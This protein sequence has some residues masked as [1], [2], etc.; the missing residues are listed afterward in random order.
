MPENTV[1]IGNVTI[2]AVKD[3]PAMRGDPGYMYRDLPSSAWDAHKRWLNE[4][5]HLD[6]TIGSF[7]VRSSGRSILVDTGIGK[8]ERPVFRT[9]RA[10]LLGNLAALGVRPEDVDLVVNTHL[11]VDHVGWNTVAQGDGWAPAFPRARYLIQ[12]KEWE[13]FTAPER[14][15]QVAYV[16]DCLEPV[17]QAGLLDLVDHQHS[18][19]PELTYFPT[20][21]HTPDHVSILV[22]SQ[23]ERALIIGDV[24]HHPVQLTETEWE[25]MADV[26]PKRA[27]ETRRLVAE[28]LER[29][30]LTVL[31]GH[32]PFPCMGRLVRLSD[33]RVFQAL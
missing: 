12:Q 20:P 24:A 16:K 9:D 33:R 17:A 8:K 11:H 14:R 2:T 13:H 21:G 6:I 30:A 25:V 32:F 26:D 5:G 4:R 1:T 23:G 18:I 3:L 29:E 31:G 22:Q 27:I 7:L 19:T 10:D 28:K 15:E